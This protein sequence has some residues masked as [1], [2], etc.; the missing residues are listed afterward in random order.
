MHFWVVFNRFERQTQNF[1]RFLFCAWNTNFRLQN[2]NYFHNKHISFQIHRIFYQLTL[3]EE[4]YFNAPQVD[5]IGTEVLPIKYQ[6]NRPK[7]FPHRILCLHLNIFLLLQSQN[8]PIF[9]VIP[10][11]SSW[12]A[13]H[14]LSD[15][16]PC[17]RT[18]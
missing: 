9:S 3:D 4:E 7:S 1:Y 16:F 2:P 14:L 5:E 15:R 13:I 10:D 6:Q 18:L 8:A 11:R 17:Q 12:T